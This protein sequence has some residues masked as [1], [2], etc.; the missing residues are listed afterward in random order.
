[1]DVTLY[2]GEEYRLL[3]R[4]RSNKCFRKSSFHYTFRS[5]DTDVLKLPAGDSHTKGAG[6]LVGNFE[7][8]P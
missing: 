7:L 3:Y 2:W 4:G 6:M 1:M 5:R 8:N